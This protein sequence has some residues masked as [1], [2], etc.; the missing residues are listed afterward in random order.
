MGGSSCTPHDTCSPRLTHCQVWLHVMKKAT[1]PCSSSSTDAVW[2]ASADKLR[3]FGEHAKMLGSPAEVP[4]RMYR[5]SCHVQNLRI[6]HPVF[7][8]CNLIQYFMIWKTNNKEFQSFAAPQTRIP[9]NSCGMCRTQHTTS[10]G[11]DA[12]RM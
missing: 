1:H 11:V 10:V 2:Q 12:W 7:S 8:H 4:F 9:S 5:G 3:W 6:L